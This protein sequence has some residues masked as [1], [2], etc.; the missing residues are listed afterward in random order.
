MEFK[1]FYL[2]VDEYGKGACWCSLDE[3]EGALRRNQTL[4]PVEYVVYK[5]TVELPSRARS[6]SI[7]VYK[8]GEF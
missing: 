2:A 4:T 5:I 7:V 6:S 3:A 1:D 8:K